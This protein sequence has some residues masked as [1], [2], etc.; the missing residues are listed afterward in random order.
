MDKELKEH[1]KE[2]RERIC[3]FISD[4]TVTHSY[5]PTIR[6]IGAGVGL[7]SSSSVHSHLTQ[8]EIEGRIE[9]K[10]YCP[11]AIRVIGNKETED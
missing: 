10:P 8:L 5:A 7:K 1:G 4:Y 11:R 3:Q 9:T 2:L 6:E